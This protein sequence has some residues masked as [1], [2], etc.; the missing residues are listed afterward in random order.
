[1]AS[2]ASGDDLVCIHDAARPLIEPADIAATLDAAEETGAAIA[3]FMVTDTVKRVASGTILE[4]VPRQDLFSATTPQVFRA[5]ILLG[6]YQ[7]AGLS[8]VTD[9]AQLVEQAGGRVRAVVTSRWNLKIT[10][11][12]DLVIAEAI[13]AEWKKREGKS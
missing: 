7:K 2:G 9:D 4:T 11:P 6:A 8:E 10:Y 5:A 1:M 13:L 12:E 3:G